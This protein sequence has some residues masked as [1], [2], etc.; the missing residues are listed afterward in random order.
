LLAVPIA[1]AI[2]VIFNNVTSFTSEAPTP[3]AAAAASNTKSAV[4]EATKT[5]EL[6]RYEQANQ[7]TEKNEPTSPANPATPVI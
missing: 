7:E 4:L 6:K 5:N 1:A 3:E 2:Q